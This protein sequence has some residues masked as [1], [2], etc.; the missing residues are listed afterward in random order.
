MTLPPLSMHL[1]SVTLDRSKARLGNSGL[2]TFNKTAGRSSLNSSLGN[3][4]GEGWTWLRSTRVAVSPEMTL[5]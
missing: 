5:M 1:A 4:F 3:T 2:G